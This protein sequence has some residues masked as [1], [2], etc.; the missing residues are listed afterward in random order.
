MV[1]TRVFY[2]CRQVSRS[3]CK[4]IDPIVSAL[5]SRWKIRT[6]IYP[7]LG[8]LF[9]KSVELSLHCQYGF[10]MLRSVAIR[11]ESQL[12]TQL[13]AALHAQPRS[14]LPVCAMMFKRTHDIDFQE[15]NT[16]QRCQKR[17]SFRYDGPLFLLRRAADWRLPQVDWDQ[18][19]DLLIG[20]D[21]PW[22]NGPILPADPSSFFHPTARLN[23]AA[24]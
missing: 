24:P 3:R 16:T 9:L 10:K 17:P 13:H 4:T 2:Y 22:T 7:C 12:H 1:A 8:L 20:R 11:G 23:F 21:S 15:G 19:P 14:R 6:C 18:Y 5:S